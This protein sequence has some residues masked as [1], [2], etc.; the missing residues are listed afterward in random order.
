MV[1]WRLEDRIILERALKTQIYWCFISKGFEV[2]INS[3]YVWHFLIGLHFSFLHQ[4]FIHGQRINIFNSI[5]CFIFLWFSIWGYLLL[6][7]IQLYNKL[8]SKYLK[9]LKKIWFL[10]IRKRFGLSWCLRWVGFCWLQRSFKFVWKRNF[11]WTLVKKI[12]IV[13]IVIFNLERWLNY[14]LPQNFNN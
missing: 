10:W 4:Y 3:L 13:I 11:I 8:T 12:H 9:C 7:N 14:L 1:M 2:Y 6:L 5:T